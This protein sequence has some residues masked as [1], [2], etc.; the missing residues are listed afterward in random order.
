MTSTSESRAQ[1]GAAV[2]R[3]CAYVAALQVLAVIIVAQQARAAVERWIVD[4]GGLLSAISS[5][6]D[7]ATGGLGATRTLVLNGAE[8]HMAVGKSP[9][10]LERVLDRAQQHCVARGGAIG[11]QLR[12]ALDA[13]QTS[14][15][16]VTPEDGML[17]GVLRI[18]DEMR[19]V[20]GCLDV[21]AQRLSWSE[22]RR[23]AREV[24]R[25][26]DVS[27]LG[28]M[29][30][31]RAERG[32]Q[33]TVYVAL[34]SDASLPIAAMFPALG[35]AP[36]VDVHGVPRP[37]HARRL[38]SVLQEGNDK[39]IVV[40]EL[41]GQPMRAAHD[42]YLAQLTAAGFSL[43]GSSPAGALGVIATRAEQS[44][45][46]TFAQASADQVLATISA[47]RD[48]TDARSLR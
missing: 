39:A 29:R 36:G 2:L 14:S 18:Q 40:Y 44:V 19:G 1:R 21:G 48:A 7:S 30:W 8:L 47:L 10:T 5:D 41:R 26:G 3:L 28:F 17:D 11:Q 46:V 31:V 35:D 16:E 22:L 33:G 25:S 13:R 42:A 24:M 15:I 23:R 27:A 12:E 32:T 37:Q 6:D 43:D 34:W 4:A 9:A 45:V 38:L 20:V